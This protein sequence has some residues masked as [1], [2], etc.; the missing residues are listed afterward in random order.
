MKKYVAMVLESILKNQNLF[1]EVDGDG[2][3]SNSS[4]RVL[5]KVEGSLFIF[6]SRGCLVLHSGGDDLIIVFAKKQCL[7]NHRIK[8]QV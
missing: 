2:E 8:K 6:L 7:A 4:K 3:L 1:K 5:G